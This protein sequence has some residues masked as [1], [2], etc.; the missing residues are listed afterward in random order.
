MFT[1]EELEIAAAVEENVH[2]RRLNRAKFEDG[3]FTPNPTTSGHGQSG[4]TYFAD[5]LSSLKSS[6][7]QVNKELIEA[8]EL[9]EDSPRLLELRKLHRELVVSIDS[10]P[11][12]SLED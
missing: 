4:T 7:A 5:D 10:N 2:M 12:G 9:P 1:F 11:S 8:R 3:D 6:L